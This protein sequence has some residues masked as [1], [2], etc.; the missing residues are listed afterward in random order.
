MMFPSTPLPDQ[1]VCHLFRDL[2]QEKEDLSSFRE[3]RAKV[4]RRERDEEKGKVNAQQS[5][6]ALPPPP[7]FF[8]SQTNV[9]LFLAERFCLCTLRKPQVCGR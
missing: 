2:E 6:P 7:P 5:L 8:G 1:L 4:E 9:A 3:K